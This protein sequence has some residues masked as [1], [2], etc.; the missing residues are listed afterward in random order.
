MGGG[1]FYDVIIVKLRQ[2]I[3]LFFDFY[4]VEYYL[5]E[6]LVDKFNASAQTFAVVHADWR[7]NPPVIASM[8]IH[9][10]TKKR[11]SIFLQ[12]I[13]EK[14]I[15]S[16]AI[17]PQVTNSPLWVERPVQCAWNENIFLKSVCS[18]CLFSDANNVLLGMFDSSSKCDHSFCGKSKR[19]AFA[20]CFFANFHH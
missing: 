15:S 12:R 14:S 20:I 9:S 16:L 19:G 1:N 7:L 18:L 8:S 6:I 17:P 11:L 4:F 5:L 2:K 3:K 10:P 13:V